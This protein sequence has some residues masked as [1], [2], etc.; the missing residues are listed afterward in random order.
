MK[1]RWPTDATE[2]CWPEDDAIVP[3]SLTDGLVEGLCADGVDLEYR[4]Y[5]DTGHGGEIEP[6]DGD[7]RAGRAVLRRVLERLERRLLPVV[8]AVVLVGHASSKKFPV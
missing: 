4:T 3:K 8:G 7:A 2:K 5:P 6:L 1:P